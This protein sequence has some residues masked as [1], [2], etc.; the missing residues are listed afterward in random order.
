[1][2][3]RVSHIAAFDPSMFIAPGVTNAAA[4]YLG[5]VVAAD[6]A[7][8]QLVELAQ[9]LSAQVQALLFTPAAQA[10]AQELPC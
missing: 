1:M 3:E 6:G 2:V 7:I 10:P 4:P 5:E 9:L 8:V